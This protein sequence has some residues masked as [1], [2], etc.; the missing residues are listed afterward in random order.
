M[1]QISEWSGSLCPVDPD[2]Y[3]INDSTG[4][5]IMA[6]DDDEPPLDPDEEDDEDEDEE[7]GEFEDDPDD[8]DD[9]EDEP[10]PDEEE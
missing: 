5:R 9:G 4:E 2:N 7:P 6:V 1:A 10:E 3:W 8:D